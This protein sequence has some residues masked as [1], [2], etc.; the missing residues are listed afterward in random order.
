MKSRQGAKQRQQRQYNR[1]QHQ[2]G[3]NSENEAND[4]KEIGGRTTSVGSRQREGLVK[5]R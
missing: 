5:E 3:V 1:V 2:G 4:S